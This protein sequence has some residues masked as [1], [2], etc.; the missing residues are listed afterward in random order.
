MDLLA[1]INFAES[2]L[3]SGLLTIVHFS[4]DFVFSASRPN[5]I[6]YSFCA[7]FHVNEM[8]VNWMS[9]QCLQVDALLDPRETDSIF[10]ESDSNLRRRRRPPCRRTQLIVHFLV[11]AESVVVFVFVICR[12]LFCC[13][14]LT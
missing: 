9:I 5:V 7:M 11:D 4:F 13:L 6:E 3:D 14:I 10:V 12:I 2:P 8:I 1:S